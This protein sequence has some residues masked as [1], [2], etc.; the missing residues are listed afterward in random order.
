[1]TPTRDPA[2]VSHRS[3]VAS[4][5]EPARVVGGGRYR[6]GRMLGR[7]ATKEVFLAH[8]TLLDRAVALAL[9]QPALAS[10]AVLRRVSEEARTMAG[11]DDHPNIVTVHD[12]G[13]DGGRVYVV[14]QYV[15]GGSLA[16]MLE[17]ASG[18]RLAVD[19]AVGI[20]RD[21]AEAL[22]HAHD[23]GLVH[24]DVKPGNV[25]LT[26]RGSALLG[27]F[28]LAVAGAGASAA[29]GLVGT[30]PYMAPEQGAA[31]DPRQ[32][33]YS[34]G[35]TLYE[36]LTGELPFRAG[37]A[38]GFLRLHRFAQRPSPRAVGGTA[39]PQALDRLVVQLMAVAPADRPA[40]AHEVRERLDAIEA[41][42]ADGRRAPR[43]R[44]VA[45]PLPPRLEMHSRSPFV[46]RE[47]A[48][49]LLLGAWE[50]TLGDDPRVVFLRGDAGV[51][52]TRLCAELAE[53]IV[54]R[55]GT[56][57]YGRCEEEP[58]AP[59][60]PFREA[61]SHFARHCPWLPDVLRLP[62]GVRL[63]RLGWPIDATAADQLPPDRTPAGRYEHFQGAVTLVK[64][65][66]SLRPLLVIFDDL[67]WA[68]VPTLRMLRHLVRHVDA[69]P[70]LLVCTIRDREEDDDRGTGGDLTPGALQLE[71]VVETVQL[72]GLSE[73]EADA[74]VDT[75]GGPEDAEL[76]H[77]LWD[78]TGGNPLYLREMLRL[79]EQELR[80]D[81]SGTIAVGTIPEAIERVLTRRLQRLAPTTQQVLRVA[82][83]LGREFGVAELA[84]VAGRS[85][86]EVL[87]ALDEATD[88][89][90]LTPAPG[91]FSRFAFSHALLRVALY[92][93]KSGGRPRELHER[94]ARALIAR[95]GD[96]GAY[97][98]QLAHHC[99]EARTRMG[100]DEALHYSEVAARF[101]SSA[102][103]YEDAVLHARRA[104]QVLDE[105]GRANSTRG[106]D[107]LLL[108]GRALWRA[109]AP[110]EARR[111]FADAA[112]LA[113]RLN[114][115]KRLAQAALG[116]GHRFYDPGK[117]DHELIGLLTMALDRLDPS[118][119][120]WRARV[121]ARL[122]DALQFRDPPESIQ[123]K[124]REALALAEAS[125]DA[126][127]TVVALE[128]LHASMLHTQ[129]LEERLEV[130][131]R[132][133]GLLRRAGRPDEHRAQAM[134]WQLYDLFEACETEAARRE[135]GEL[136]E[137][138]KY[139][140]QPL[141]LHFAAAW[142]AKLKELAGDFDAAERLAHESLAQARRA[143]MPYARSNYDGQLFALRRDR[144][145]LRG[146]SDEVRRD[147]GRAAALPVWR[148]GLVLASL[149][150]DEPRKAR[151]A[152]A[153]FE[154]LTHD[155]FAA[156]PRDLFWLG[157][158]CLLA[159]AC[160]RLGDVDVAER[161]LRE[162][163]PF[164]ARNAQIGLAVNVGTVRRFLGILEATRGRWDAAEAHF[165]QALERSA[166]MGAEPSAAH[167]ELEY[168]EML[169]ARGAPGDHAH[170][171]D[172]LDA[173][174]GHARR[175]SL[176]PVRRRAESLKRAR[177]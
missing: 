85:R 74:F 2:A 8:D 101:A 11:L 18:G 151:E 133:L 4:P 72:G 16:G 103:A 7:G 3:T 136:D 141:Y 174:E 119:T 113:L 173:V 78:R 73:P 131:E 41:G 89:G 127:A 140:Q 47:D 22:A 112:D 37:D 52:K 56:V 69:A 108:S 176:E 99:F 45:V 126:Q 114:D 1:M 81:L 117:V 60:Q 55:G 102:L 143:G 44:R 156:V 48:M 12:V 153:E 82:A 70:I 29:T 148:A 172:R 30:L 43:A 175:L 106:I 155:G 171:L 61:L 68:D 62:P 165:R 77:R 152:R 149:D 93:T 154:A 169:L 100:D 88:H 10:P 15:T 132:L 128:G 31:P 90:I 95:H 124:S 86:T 142:E 36:I 50:A 107:L 42:G 46:G 32:D 125:G 120:A 161:L 71:P 177:A 58:I 80:A 6:L 110:E 115:P 129:Y 96:D 54:T 64:A 162:L 28:G 122:A 166:Q 5:E 51:G 160:G 167:I 147:L 35:V 116:F 92:G 159:E 146:L 118:E 168:A 65:M 23:R 94:C 34:L 135:H 121:L 59:Y 91:S 109:S 130:S 75:R 20:A 17:V 66:A 137:I 150:D 67:Q 144:G 25:F 27:D 123:A 83:V 13:E 158:M 138:A 14:S 97:A 19:V 163:E 170:A 111:T 21:V 9:V 139:L 164:E 76:R 24:R 104:L 40:S 38:D 26:D 49:R 98:A 134:H 105:Q 57:L 145:R 63:E 84:E 87:E 157:A 33:L 53:R 79:G 39:I